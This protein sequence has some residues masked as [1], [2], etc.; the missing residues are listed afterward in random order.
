MAK[1]SKE[2][3]DKFFAQYPVNQH[4]DPARFSFIASKLEGAVLDF[5]CGTGTLSD[6]YS[7]EYVGVDFSAVAIEKAKEVRRKDALFFT[8]DLEAEAFKAPKLF[9][10]AYCGEFLEHIEDDRNIFRTLK[11]S[12][13]VGGLAFFSV[14]NGDR[15]PDESH[16]RIFTVPQIR[17]EYSKY[18]KVRFYSWPG[19]LQRIIFSIE[20]GTLPVDKI[21]LVMI[22][23]DEGKGIERAI[24]SALP[25]VDYVIV[26]VDSLTTDNTKEIAAL[27]ADELKEHVWADDFSAARNYAQENVVTPWILFLDGHEYIETPGA[28]QNYI[29][30][31][32]E[33]MFVTVKMESGMTFLYPRIFK[34]HIK[35]KNAVHNLNEVKTKINLADFVIVHD[36]DNGQSEEARERRNLQRD[37]MMPRIMGEQLR[38]N[39]RHA[40]ALFHLG[41]HAL[42]IPDYPKAMSYYKRYMKCYK[43]PD[44]AYMVLLNIGFI[45]A[46]WGHNT[47]ALWAFDK[48][49]RL[50]PGRWETARVL[51]GLYLTMGNHK[52]ALEYFVKALDGN[53]RTYFYNPI[54]R[55]LVELWD[56]IGTCFAH[57]DQNKQ[58][59]AAFGRAFDLCKDEEKKNIFHEKMK[60]I[61][62]LL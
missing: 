43:S 3:Y 34:S 54:P 13:K 17:R 10:S 59:L 6:Y 56:F 20:I 42:M 4:D 45:R 62:T 5:A 57:L 39:P 31:D 44:E 52:R 29:D 58:A 33:G 55:D 41:N 16:C 15:V 38:Q 12:V 18:G 61:K 46:A 60:L 28:L 23:K 22:A 24:L 1:Q 36:R 51:G 9:D 35:F 11:K 21:S 19:E 8:L 40:R 30:S 7:G 25:I 27:Y 37:E 14:P 53:S 2:F 49:D 32:V 50:L 47:R 26:S 48:A